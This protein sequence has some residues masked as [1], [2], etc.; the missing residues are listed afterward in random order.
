[1]TRIRYKVQGNLLISNEIVNCEGARLTV[2]IQKHLNEDLYIVYIL[3]KN[4]VLCKYD[5]LK[6]QPAKRL[7]RKLLTNYG[8]NLNEE[9]RP[10]RSAWI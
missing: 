10:R 8:V 7:A 9:I 5:S 4:S 3:N 1:M 6:L 2:L